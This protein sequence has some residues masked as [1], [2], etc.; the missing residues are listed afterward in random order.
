MGGFQKFSSA[1]QKILMENQLGMGPMVG[2]ILHSRY[3]TYNAQQAGLTYADTHPIS[4]KDND[5]FVRK[6]AL[7]YRLKHLSIVKKMKLQ[8]EQWL[9]D[10]MRSAI[11]V[12]HDIKS[13]ENTI[14]S[15]APF[16]WYTGF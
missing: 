11:N 8:D 3:A 6:V 15:F 14:K 1:Q 10:E 4:S 2:A 7:E 13:T 9:H 16:D 12:I 5:E